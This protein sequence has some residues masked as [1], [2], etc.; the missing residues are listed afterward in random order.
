M[1][2]SALLGAIPN[3]DGATYRLNVNDVAK[4]LATLS[5]GSAAPDPA[6]PRQLWWDTTANRLKMRTPANSGWVEIGWWT[7]SQFRPMRDG[8]L[9]GTAATRDAGTAAD[10]VVALD[11]N[12]RL[13]AIDASQLI[14]LPANAVTGDLR[15]ALETT[16][17]A[18]WL[19]CDGRTL[20]TV[21]SGAGHAGASYEALFGYL[22]ERIANAWCPLHDSAGAPASRGGSA[23][24]D[25]AANRRLA[26]PDARGSALLVRDNMG[27]VAAGRVTSAST[28][29]ANATSIAARGGA[30]THALTG[31]QLPA[32]DV[33][34][35]IRTRDGQAG[36]GET[37]RFGYEDVA[38]TGNIMA[39]SSSQFA[40][41]YPYGRIAGGGQ[42]HS[43]M[44]AWFSLALL[45]K[46]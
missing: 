18:G 24:A 20:G 17:P 11:A 33:R 2:Q 45:I 39:P 19:F 8:V 35:P 15:L 29:G 27:G 28:D 13:P 42:A 7:G 36:Q 34:L 1:T 6:Y 32:A 23:A 16:A 37:D 40:Y 21:A 30:E 43:S 41:R 46:V 4:A 14:H 5:E 9:L 12:A 10:Q 44:G 26:L 31:A 22:W 25:W 38:E 3:V